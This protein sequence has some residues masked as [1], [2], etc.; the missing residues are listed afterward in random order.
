M[1]TLDMVEKVKKI[2]IENEH[3]S[4]DVLASKC[5]MSVQ[6]IYRIIRVMRLQGVG[7]LV[8]PNGYILS[9]YATKKDDV[10][11]LRRLNGRRTSDIIALKAAEPDIKKRWNAIPDKKALSLIVG[12]LHTDIGA[13]NLGLETLKKLEDPKGIDK[14]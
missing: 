5:N 2:L 14:S 9:K 3:V 6:S 13:L 8:T 7:V 4:A 10:H 11:F 1:K 12:P